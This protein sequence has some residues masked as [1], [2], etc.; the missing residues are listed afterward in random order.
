[1]EVEREAVMEGE[2]QVAMEGETQVAMQRETQV[3]MQGD[4]QVAMEGETQ[5]AMEGESQVAMEGESHVAMEG[6]TQVA[7]EGETQVAMEDVLQPSPPSS[8]FPAMK[9]MRRLRKVR[10]TEIKEKDGVDEVRVFSQKSS[11][12]DVRLEC[13]ETAEEILK[14]FGKGGD[15]GCEGGKKRKVVQSTIM[16]AVVDMMKQ[17]EAVPVHEVVRV[18][19]VEAEDEEQALQSH[20]EEI[21]TG[22]EGDIRRLWCLWFVSYVN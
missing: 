12:S 21:A 17:V 3:A 18:N 10:E 5:V 11:D 7:M 22:L 20:G 8:P 15:A 13:R 14:R 19:T 2:T 4:T 16:A 6:E 9:K 1:M